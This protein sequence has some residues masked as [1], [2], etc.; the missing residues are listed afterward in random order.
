[1]AQAKL[2]LKDILGAI[3][4]GA[5][6][7]WDELNDEEKKQIN[8]WLLNRYASSVQ[9]NREAQELAIFKTNEYYNKHYNTI[10]KESKLLWMLLC[11]TANDKKSLRFHK[12]LGLKYGKSSSKIINLLGSIY[13]N[14][15]NEELEMLASM[16]TKK[17]LK[18]L[19]IQHGYDEKELDKVLK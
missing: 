15:K 5:M 19:G 6:S 3:D 10:R 16:N 9:G 18:E 2:P 11:L 12:W 8:F 13:P 1:M 17:D 7:V 4:M 14:A